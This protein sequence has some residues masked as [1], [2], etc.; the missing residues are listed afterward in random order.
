MLNDCSQYFI[1]VLQFC[2]HVQVIVVNTLYTDELILSEHNIGEIGCHSVHVV[3]SN[4]WLLLLLQ[5]CY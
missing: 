1:L 2:K 3:L 5:M 4:Q